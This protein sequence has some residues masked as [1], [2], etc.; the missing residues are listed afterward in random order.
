MTPRRKPADDPRAPQAGADAPPLPAQVCPSCGRPTGS[1]AEDI[2]SLL[3]IHLPKLIDTAAN[4][5]DPNVSARLLGLLEKIQSKQEM[6]EAERQRAVDALEMV[7]QA[8]RLSAEQIGERAVRVL[9]LGLAME[10]G[11]LEGWTRRL[12]IAAGQARP[13]VARETA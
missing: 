10:P 13:P 12:R 8:E 9:E 2:G 3:L 5:N 11:R 1:D 7:R 6:D 4:S